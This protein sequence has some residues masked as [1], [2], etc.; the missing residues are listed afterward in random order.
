MEFV[1][2]PSTLLLLFGAAT[3]AAFVDAIA[4]GGGLITLPAL[5]VAGV[6]PLGA[7]GTNKAQSVFG[8]GTASV[9][10]L[11]KRVV[12]AREVAP[13]VWRSA[14]GAAFG[15]AAVQQLDTDALDIAIPLVLLLI[16][17]Y[18]LFVPAAGEFE[19]T[20][21]MSVSAYRNT[22]VPGIGAY[23]G[24]LGPGTGSFFAVSGVALRG[25]RLVK[26]TAV[27]KTLN[28]ASNGAAL[29]VFI[30]GGEVVWKAAIV[31]MGGQ[32]LGGFVGAHTMVRGGTRLIRP[33]VVATSVAMLIRFFT[34]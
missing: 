11:R 33:L 9:T 19:S 17:G 8:S 18:F 13:S 10:L 27:A 16:G 32:I 23:D 29:V 26:A 4:G 20:P 14:V 25:L 7:I 31:M 30:I 15:A 5:L 3:L 21:R 12:T 34:A 2:D 1:A 6:S 28:F 22:V 24:V